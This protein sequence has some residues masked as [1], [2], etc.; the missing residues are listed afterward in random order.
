MAELRQPLGRDAHVSHSRPYPPLPFPIVELF[1][2]LPSLAAPGARMA[3]GATVLLLALGTVGLSGG[4]TLLV[5]LSPAGMVNLITG[6]SGLFVA[7]LLFAAV[8]FAQTGRPAATGIN[9]AILAASRIWGAACCRCSS[10]SAAL[11]S[12]RARPSFRCPRSEESC[13]PTA[14]RHG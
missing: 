14:P 8:A 3:A 12:W 2:L 6:Q 9:W 5:L 13:W 1:S 7:A 10:P 11:R 4:W